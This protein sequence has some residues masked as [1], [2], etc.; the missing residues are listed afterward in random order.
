MIIRTELEIIWIVKGK[1]FFTKE[2]AEK[3]RDKLIKNKK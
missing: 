2:E 3:Y 1:K